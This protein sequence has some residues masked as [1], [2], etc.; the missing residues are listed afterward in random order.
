VG[1]EA[2]AGVVE[3][4]ADCP[5]REDPTAPAPFTEAPPNQNGERIRARY[6]QGSDGSSLFYDLYDAELGWPCEVREVPENPGVSPAQPVA[7]RFNIAPSFHTTDPTCAQRDLFEVTHGAP[8]PRGATA[9]ATGPFYFG[10]PGNCEPVDGLPDN[11]DLYETAPP[12]AEED[13]VRFQTAP[14][15][16]VPGEAILSLGEDGSALW[17]GDVATYGVAAETRA[18]VGQDRIWPRRVFSPSASTTPA[19]CSMPA[20]R[21]DAHRSSDGAEDDLNPLLGRIHSEAAF[22][23]LSL[24][25]LRSVEGQMLWRV[26]TAQGCFASTLIADDSWGTVDP[27]D[28]DELVSVADKEVGG[29]RLSVI[30]Q[31]VGPDGVV[32]PRPAAYSTIIDTQLEVECQPRLATDDVLRCLPS[33]LD[34]VTDAVYADP[35][36]E[37]LVIGERPVGSLIALWRE[38]HYEVRRATQE[39]VTFTQFYRNDGAVCTAL[40]YPA[41]GPLFKLSAEVP[42]SEFVAFEVVE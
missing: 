18:I 16:G 17:L 6:L 2:G 29:T 25:L 28:A 20:A 39:A 34:R 24:G 9:R 38:G 12:A 21:R 10:Y 26:Q 40:P 36:C 42:P 37:Q 5:R 22:G 13:F 19:D 33:S 15:T 31:A 1:G 11:I 4:A 8:A 30:L 3:F 32:V 14:P 35:A 7:C 27:C 23:Q 41:G